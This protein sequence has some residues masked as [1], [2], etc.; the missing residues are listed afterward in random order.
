MMSFYHSGRSALGEFAYRKLLRAAGAR[1][2][3]WAAYRELLIKVLRDP[4]ILLSVH[5]RAMA[6]PLSMQLPIWLQQEPAYDR[7]LQR[8]GTFIRHREGQI[9]AIDVG[10]NIGDSIAAIGVELGDRFL[11]IEPSERFFRYLVMNWGLVSEVTSLQAACASGG[12]AESFSVDHYRRGTATVVRA[13]PDDGL[14]F[15]TLDAIVQSIPAFEEIDL[16]KIDTDGWDLDVIRGAEETIRRF[17]PIVLFEVDSFSEASYVDRCIDSLNFFG[18]AGYGG[19]LVYD[20]AGF[21]VG[22]HQIDALES[23]RELL[24][25]QQ[26]LSAIRKTGVLT[27]SAPFYFDVLMLRPDDMRRFLD[28]EVAWLEKLADH[29]GGRYAMSPVEAFTQKLQRLFRQRLPSD[30]ENTTTAKVARFGG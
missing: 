26:G 21:L 8:L 18:L 30:N 10:A 3:A 13:P 7:L 16:L 1:R 12:A 15:K 11:A 22:H 9:R 17:Q 27:I 6:M 19:F 5:G 29:M 24:C 20:N 4:T 2:V 25:Y 28:S 14:A 23:F